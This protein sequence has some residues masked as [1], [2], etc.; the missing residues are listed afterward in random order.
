MKPSAMKL[1]SPSVRASLSA[2][3]LVLAFSTGALSAT[4][5]GYDAVQSS[6]SSADAARLSEPLATLYE[7]RG[8]IF[9]APKPHLN[10]SSMVLTVS[11]P[12]GYYIHEEFPN[13][14]DPFVA[15]P[16]DGSYT[17]E[18]YMVSRGLA[19][20]ETKRPA[21]AVKFEKG[22]DENGR[23]LVA[24]A[25]RSLRSA[26]RGPVQSGYFTIKDGMLVDPDIQ[27]E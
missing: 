9:W 2:L 27:E 17:Y 19:I 14:D 6:A 11:G 22:I 18:L 16:N 25:N 10:Y 20:A 21:G 12:D 5:P 23:S 26:K 13:G 7:D 1:I 8:E 15:N 24:A 4:G 3:F